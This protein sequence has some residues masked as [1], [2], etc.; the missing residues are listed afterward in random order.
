MSKSS[1]MLMRIFYEYTEDRRVDSI[2]WN[3]D[4]TELDFMLDVK[5]DILADVLCGGHRDCKQIVY[6]HFVRNLQM[7]HGRN[8][9]DVFLLDKNGIVLEWDDAFREDE[10]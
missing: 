7:Y 2:E 6:D 3:D 8:H 4:E 1:R 5:D 10:E 9:R